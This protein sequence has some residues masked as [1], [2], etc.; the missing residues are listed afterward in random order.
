MKKLALFF[1]PLLLLLYFNPLNAAPFPDP[2]EE[3]ELIPEGFN[4]QAIARDASGKPIADK[5]ISVRISMLNGEDGGFVEY[6][7]SHKVRTDGLGQFSIVI[8]RGQKEKGSFL[9]IPWGK[10][11]QWMQMELD[12][13]GGDDYIKMGKTQLMSVPYAL[14][15]KSA[16]IDSAMLANMIGSSGGGGGCRQSA[17]P[18]QQTA[19]VSMRTYNNS[20]GG[21]CA[22]GS[23]VLIVEDIV[24]TGGSI[25]EIITLL[26]NQTHSIYQ[27]QKVLGELISKEIL[28]L[29]I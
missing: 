28:P 7:E 22:E 10:G 1:I 23:N 5:E 26:K 8:G 24:T 13:D 2:G 20:G 25:K 12:P 14:Y 17:Q 18:V 16:G 29:E 3:K 6:I 21:C 4:Y 11:N 9:S 19:L 27:E 15:A